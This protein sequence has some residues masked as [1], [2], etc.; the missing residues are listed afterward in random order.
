MM[1]YRDSS[2]SLDR[3]LLGISDCIHPGILHYIFDFTVDGA[4]NGRHRGYPLTSIKYP[5]LVTREVSSTTTWLA[6]W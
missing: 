6:S 3:A 2:L 1:R 4:R 5:C